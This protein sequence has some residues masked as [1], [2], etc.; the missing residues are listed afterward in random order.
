M[1]RLL[2]RVS[3]FLHGRKSDAGNATVEF[4]VVFPVIMMIFFQSFEAGWLMVRYTM[5]DRSLDITV[6]DLRL[7][8]FVNPTADTL[9]TNIC[10]LALGIQ[11]CQNALMVELVP[12]DTTS[13][14]LPSPNATCVNRGATIQPVTTVTQG[15]GDE[16]MIIR[17]CAIVDP[18]FPGTGLGL[19]LPKDASGGFALVATS[20]FVNEPT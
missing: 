19:D 20:A 4:V 6:R 11:D 14:N 5:L 18:L 2:T 9:R 16:M 3:D 1:T 13:W 15:T 17:A 10:S 8:H 7:G 12:V